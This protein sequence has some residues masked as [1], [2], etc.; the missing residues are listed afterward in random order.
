MSEEISPTPE[1]EVTPDAIP[2]EPIVP[3]V[4]INR[5][6]IGL[7]VTLQILLGVCLF[8]LVNYL[9]L[10]HFVQWD[11][12]YDREFTL[13]NDT[14]T[15]LKQLD[16]KLAV[17]VI[18]HKGTPE[19]KDVWQ[20]V[21]SFHRESKGKL[22]IELVDPVKDIEAFDKVSAEAAKLR[23]NV[24]DLGILIRVI[25]STSEAAEN[26][27]APLPAASFIPLNSMFVYTKDV[28]QNP[29]LSG[30]NGESA[31][32]GGLMSISEGNP[33]KLYIVHFGKSKLR[34][35]PT[36]GNA[37]NVI[38][39]MAARQN[40]K[41]VPLPLYETDHIPEDASAVLLVGLDNDLSA[42]EIGTL[43]EYWRGKGHALFI[44]L[45]RAG[46]YPMPTLN[47]FLAENG[48]V[49]QEDRVMRTYG[50]AT[51]TQKVFENTV[52]ILDNSPITKA[53]KGLVT[54][55]PGRSSSLKLTPEAE[56]PR[57]E[58]IDI[59]PLLSPTTG[60]WGEKNYDDESPQ[61]GPDDNAP[62]LYTAASLERGASRDAQIS[63]DSSRMVVIANCSLLDPDILL[64]ENQDFVNSCV[65]WLLQRDKYI[66]IN[67]TPRSTYSLKIT[68]EQKNRIFVL[69]TIV[70]PLAIFLLG[71]FIWG[72][73]RS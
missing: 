73:R 37:I 15:F 61:A 1:A 38:S 44:M 10:R 69:T 5:R 41:L 27:D 67:P 42:R 7:N 60:Y 49:P 39:K 11:K 62:P 40:M 24:G 21:E 26:P 30:F 63:M 71:V 8:G 6:R 50:T 43:R 58:N 68:P 47:A 17:T 54:T 66:G 48:V 31:L 4:P 12:T 45:N 9:G 29:V 22:K 23:I 3:L 16:K 25:K 56:L 70:L 53:Q 64:R 19:H 18:C 14:L 28:N 65:N 52:T 51:G 2:P 46:D 34:S 33:P 35:V 59:K 13:S 36:M 20:L 72:S 32:T 57:T 55:I